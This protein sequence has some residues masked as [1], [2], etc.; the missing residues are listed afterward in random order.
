MSSR[1]SPAGIRCSAEHS[2]AASPPST[3]SAPE[4]GPRRWGTSSSISRAPGRPEAAKRPAS[5][6]CPA[7]SNVTANPVTGSSA[8]PNSSAGY[9]PAISDT[10]TSGGSAD[11]GQKA[12]TVAPT[13]S[14]P[15]ATVTSVTAPAHEP[16][17]LASSAVGVSSREG[18]ATDRS[19]N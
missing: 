11:T 8:R 1:W 9:D 12:L 5:T 14:R 13:S 3:I 7:D 18:R 4:A 6:R 16:H 10:S 17:A 19:V 2:S 15:S